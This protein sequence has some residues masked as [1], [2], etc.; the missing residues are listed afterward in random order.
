MAAALLVVEARAQWDPA[1]GDWSVSSVVDVRVMTWNVRDGV[2]SSAD[3][4]EGLNQWTAVARIVAAMRPDVLLLQEMGDNGAAGADSVDALTVTITLFLRGGV[5]PFMVGQPQV[6]SYVA[7]YSPG[8][9]LPYVFVSEETDGYNRNV[10][11]SRYPFADLNGD[12]RSA[13]SD[14]P[15]VLPDVYA[16]GGDGGLRGFQFA[17][18]GLDDDAYLGDLVVGNAH[19]KSGGGSTDATLRREASQNVA[20]AIDHW[21]NG[22]G[23]GVPDPHDVMEDDPP[24]QRVLDAATPIVI[25]GDWTEDEWTNDARGPADWLTQAETPGGQDGTDRDRSDATFDGA[26]HVFTGGRATFGNVKLDYVAWQD[27]LV[28]PRRAFVFDTAGTPIFALPAEL[29]GFVLP[30]EASGYASDHRPVVVDLI[31]PLVF[32]ADADGDVD[33]D[34]FTSF[35]E[36]LIAGDAC[37]VHDGDR[38]GDVDLVDFGALMTRFGSAG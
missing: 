15:T 19:L 4:S 32:D 18:F 11:L 20:Y 9:D 31:L 16:P 14:I 37:S 2:R 29:G 27:S 17:E 24:A 30:A 26:F 21:F 35:H 13:L 8:Y 10:M 36:C 33:L 5:D 23:E 6:T 34:D 22:A 3:K 12:G 25:G 7:K 1:A 38:D 28:A